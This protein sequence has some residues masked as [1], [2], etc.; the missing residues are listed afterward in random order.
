[1]LYSVIIPCYKSSHTIRQVVELTIEELQKLGKTPFEFVLV[2]DASPDGGETLR[3]LH[4]LAEDHDSVR[5]VELASNAGQHNAVMA[6]LNECAGDVII[7]MDDDLQ[8]HP[9]QL[10]ALFEGFEQGYDIA[11]G[12]YPEKKHSAFRNFGSWG[13]YMS[14]RILINKPKELKT[15]S[16]WIIRRFVRDYVIQ[17][18]SS[19]THLQGLFLRT[20]K[21]IISVPIQ[22]F[23]RA[24]G[25]SGYTL[26]KLVSL[27][28]NI[29]GYSIV[30]LRMARNVGFFFSLI[31]FLG[32]IAIVLKKLIAPTSAV[33]WFS[34]MAAIFFFSGLIMMFLGIIGEYLGRMYLAQGNNPQY[35]VRRIYTGDDTTERHGDKQ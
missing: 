35:V 11:Y 20:T 21:N 18:R 31:G 16:F 33:G 6:G 7:C 23:D 10:P 9:S 13:N 27:W 32:A 15:S 34:M 19:F 25:Q 5:I 26:K 17:Y 30:P 12:Y 3:Q 14:V 22:H 1:M 8:T 2:D 24:Y 29:M 28:S 4:G